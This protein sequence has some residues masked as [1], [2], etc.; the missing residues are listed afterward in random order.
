MDG[1][2]GEKPALVFGCAQPARHGKNPKGRFR[3]G[4]VGENEWILVGWMRSGF[5]SGKTRKT[6]GQTF[7]VILFLHL[8]FVHQ[9]DKVWAFENGVSK[10][11]QAMLHSRPEAYMVPFTWSPIQSTPSTTEAWSTVASY[12]ANAGR[13]T[14]SAED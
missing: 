3:Y 11:L 4:R 9:V 13:K 10:R 2:L 12:T 7:T 6:F 14:G 1:D 8:V 5:R